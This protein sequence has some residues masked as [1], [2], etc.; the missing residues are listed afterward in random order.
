MSDT[1]EHI[2]GE[3]APCTPPLTSFQKPP[4][5][6]LGECSYSTLSQYTRLNHMS[7]RERDLITVIFDLCALDPERR[8]DMQGVCA[9]LGIEAMGKQGVGVSGVTKRLSRLV[10]AGILVKSSVTLPGRNKAKGGRPATLYTVQSTPTPLPPAVNHDASVKLQQLDLF[11]DAAALED[12]WRRT[13]SL[14]MDDFWCQLVSSVLPLSDR[15]HK[16]HL[17]TSINYQAEELPI[18]IQSRIGSRIPTIR[19]IKTVI[20]LFTIV[21]MTIKQCKENNTAVGKRFVADV[22]DVLRLMGLPNEGGNRRTVIQHLMEWES[23][24][25]KFPRLNEVV[26]KLLEERFGAGAFGFAHHQL[27]S[28]LCGVGVLKE[29]QKI[30]THIGF[31]LPADLVRRIEDEGVYNLF[32]VTPQFMS[33]DNPLAMAFHLYCRKNLGHNRSRTLMPSLR[34]LHERLCKDIPY[35]D[36]KR[37]LER[38]IAQKLAVRQTDVAYQKAFREL[39]ESETKT[40]SQ[41]VSILGYNITLLGDRVSIRVDL[42]DKYVGLGSTHA[43]LE[44]RAEQEAAALAEKEYREKNPQAYRD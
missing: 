12:I 26:Q 7:D 30:P 10:L 14:R 23:T 8:C 28:Q 2:D 44:Q 36:F 21:E 18:E 13:P 27:I 24:I 25:F 42:D 16:T 31:E 40:Y 39:I 33:E 6:S 17:L 32:T 37:A 20:A 19:S 5:F 4:F 38:L 3:C 41:Q 22:G 11:T 9:R 34:T 35:L 15:T 43:R 29:G 1:Y